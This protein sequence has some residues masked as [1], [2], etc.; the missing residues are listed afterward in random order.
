MRRLK[1]LKIINIKNEVDYKKCTFCSI[2]IKKD[3]LIS[4][5]QEKCDF[6]NY[7]NISE[8]L[9]CFKT[10]SLYV[11][12]DICDD[13]DII[14]VDK[15]DS[16]P[17]NEKDNIYLILSKMKNIVDNYIILIESDDKKYNNFLNNCGVE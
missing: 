13:N 14:I 2:D 7:T 16:F 17:K 10:D 6:F 15:F 1:S 4:M 12:R 8:L 11:V 9:N 5:L 3:I